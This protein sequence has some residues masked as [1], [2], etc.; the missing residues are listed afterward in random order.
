MTRSACDR[1][2][3]ELLTRAADRDATA[4]DHLRSCARCRASAAVIGA[5]HAR[6]A[7]ARARDLSPA[8]RAATLRRAAKALALRRTARVLPFARPVFARLAC[9]AALAAVLAAAALFAVMRGAPGSAD[10]AAAARPAAV[11]AADWDGRIRVQRRSLA[12][13][14]DDFAV[15]YLAR[16][17][18]VS[19]D[20]RTSDLRTRIAATALRAGRDLPAGT[21]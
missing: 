5:L 15:K 2:M 13:D 3:R 16:N 7:A 1:T 11:M 17:R 8:A 19:F 4:D 21:R 6:G 9:A 12:A 14:I 20:A 10:A 18:S